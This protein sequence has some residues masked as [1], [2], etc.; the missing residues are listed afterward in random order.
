MDRY[1]GADGVE[2]RREISRLAER[3]AVPDLRALADALPPTVAFSYERHRARALALALE[4]RTEQAVA[5]LSRGSAAGW[6]ETPELATDLAELRLVAGDPRA[7]V[8]AIGLAAQSAGRL[9]PPARALLVRAVVAERGLWHPA[10]RVALRAGKPWLRAA[11]A[12][13]VLAAAAGASGAEDDRVRVALGGLALAVAILAFVLLPQVIVDRQRERP[14]VPLVVPSEPPA[15]TV[16][17][18]PRRRAPETTVRRRARPAPATAQTSPARLVSRS[19]G[20][21]VRSRLPRIRPVPRPRVPAPAPGRIQ[22]PAPQRPPAAPP[23]EPVASEP[24]PGTAAPEPT[25]GAG[26]PAVSPGTPAS[27][28]STEAPVVATK[29]PKRGNK[30]EKRALAGAPAQA[31]APGPPAETPP[32]HAAKPDHGPPHEKGRAEPPGQAKKSEERGK[33]R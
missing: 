17:V 26:A 2:L 13:A 19:G 4:R 27:V 3:G 1:T 11:D 9:D 32:A 8:T 15:R 30:R 23:T 28:A 33:K 20:V 29:A 12:L 21:P 25:D 10:T 5:E 31:A 7:A 16:A 22:P 6:P 24:S 18:V 14:G